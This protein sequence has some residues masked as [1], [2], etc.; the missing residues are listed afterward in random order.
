[1]WSCQLK[2]VFNIWKWLIQFKFNVLLFRTILK[3]KYISLT[4]WR[5]TR[6]SLYR[7]WTWLIFFV[8]LIYSLRYILI[9][10]LLIRKVYLINHWRFP[11]ILALKGNTFIPCSEHWLF[12][13][14]IRFIKLWFRR[15]IAYTFLLL[16]LLLISYLRKSK[17]LLSGIQYI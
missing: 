15:L 5:F 12:Y 16:M 9:E 10:V 3:C 7:I 17:N 14:V 13:S 6:W 11:W 2:W 1:M 8:Y 4:W